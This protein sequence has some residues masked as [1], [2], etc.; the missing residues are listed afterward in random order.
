M[1]HHFCTYFNRTYLLRGL[2][3]YRSLKA[4]QAEPF[5]LWALCF[6][7][8][9]YEV[10]DRLKQPDLRPIARADF[11]RG[12]E[13]LQAAQKT[14]STIE[15]YF[16]C[17]PSLPLYILKCHPDIDRITYLD[18]DLFFFA[19]SA[20]IFEEMGSGSILITPHRFAPALRPME[21]HGVYNV[22]LLSF[23]NDANG[24]DCLS[25]WRD[26]C[27]EWCYDRLEN[28]KFADQKYLDDWPQRFRG[29]VVQ[30]HKGCNLA[31]WN[32]MNYR[33]AAQSGSIRVDEDPLIF[34]HYQ[35]LKLLGPRIYDPNVLAYGTPMPGPVLKLLYAPYLD[36]LQE[37]LRWVRNIVPTAD[38]GYVGMFSRGYGRRALIKALLNRQLRLLL[39]A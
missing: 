11:E 24:R 25:W 3:L 10:L 16:T 32:W 21:A 29:V 6:D 27:I 35:G 15:Y 8:E 31:P 17:S 1:I 13:A 22:G 34:Y 36:A 4:H 30:Q 28:G 26:R 20:P 19:D 23:R 37:T 18:A 39:G 14:R 5:L 9:A 33:L 7:D 38:P 12:D 2:A